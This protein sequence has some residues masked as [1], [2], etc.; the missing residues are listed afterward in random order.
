MKKNFPIILLLIFFLPAFSQEKS[1]PHSYDH[2]FRIPKV[3]FN[4]DTTI[5]PFPT[6][7]HP[8]GDMNLTEKE[9]QYYTRLIQE[10]KKAVSGDSILVTEEHYLWKPFFDRLQYEDP[11]YLVVPYP[12]VF[13]KKMENKIHVL[14]LELL[15]IN[16][17]VIVERSLDIQF[18]KGDRI[19]SIN[20]VP[21]TTYLKYYNKRYIPAHIL[22]RYNHFSFSPH[23]RVKVIRNKQETEV[24]TA[25][26][27]YSKF[28]LELGKDDLQQKI[29]KEAGAG[30][31]TLNNFYPNN[32]R[33]IGVLSSFIRKLK[34]EGCH[35]LIIDVRKNP[36]GNGDRF[37]KLLSLFINKP[38]VPYLISQ[39]VR[40]SEASIKDYD[41]FTQDMLGKVVDIP[42]PYLIKEFKTYPQLYEEGMN[43]YVLISQYTAS[44][45]ASFVNILQYNQAATLVGEDLAHNALKYGEVTWVWWG[46]NMH[47]LISTT[48]INE[49]TLAV[50]GVLKP[51]IEIPYVAA[52]YL[53][54]GDAMLVKLLDYIK[55][56]QN[57]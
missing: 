11:H 5:L 12:E 3:A 22:Q 50:D 57:K 41:F 17:T 10:R 31:I 15:V 6:E 9:K 56:V 20:D 40:V 48:E 51:D 8:A 21:V 49:H 36:G 26:M 19:L 45:A 54:G 23:Y 52:D 43:Y 33:V 4:K 37:D 14:P 18:Q 30:Y 32:S 46:Y 44:I 35:H 28:N 7:F 29:F 53:G 13:Q 27:P 55:T 1:N 39:K 2:L 16:D 42:E 38:V 34:K 47:Q 24:Q 25:G